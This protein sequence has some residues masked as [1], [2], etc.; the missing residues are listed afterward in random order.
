MFNQLRRR[1]GHAL[2]LA[3]DA[4]FSG[5]PM[6]ATTPAATANSAPTWGSPP[7]G[8]TAGSPMRTVPSRARIG[9]GNGG[10]SSSCSS[11]A[12]VC[13]RRRPNTGSWW[14]RSPPAST[15]AP[16]CMRSWRSSGCTCGRCRWSALPTTNRW[17]RGCGVPARSRC[18]RSP[19]AC[20]HG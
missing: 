12:A 15:T 1:D 16:A 10:W 18:D 8:T 5:S 17:W 4:A 2:L 13:S 9:T 20:P 7:R 3:G 11:A 14:L 19:T 6:Q